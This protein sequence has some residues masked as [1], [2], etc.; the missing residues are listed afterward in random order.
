MRNEVQNMSTIERIGQLSHRIFNTT[1]N[2]QNVRRESN[3]FAKSNFQ[4]N[5]LT[6]DVLELSSKK[7]EVSFTGAAK[8]TQGTK[9][10]YSMFVSSISN[11]GKKFYEGVE[12]I[13]EFGARMLES[14]TNVFKKVK[15]I[16][17]TEIHVGEGIKKGYN[18]VK[19]KL[20]MDVSDL[21]NTR[22]HHISK[23]SKMD[24]QTEIKP[25]LVEGIK[26]LEEHM[27]QAA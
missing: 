24:P 12:S 8:I 4:K 6:A 13:K 5:V 11:L 26:A 3:P 14:A 21:V 20:S 15:E 1:A 10:I 2:E 27:L 25:L 7:N 23:M 18:Y 19:D 9:R 22:S 16:A 17:N